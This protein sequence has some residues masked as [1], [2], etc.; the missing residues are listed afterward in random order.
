[1]IENLLGNATLEKILLS[2]QRYGDIY[3]NDIANTFDISLYCVQKQFQKMERSGVM[4]SR[5]YGKVRLYQF[6]PNYPLLNELR[7]LLNKT[8]D[9]LPKRDI[10][11]YYMKRQRPRLVGKK[12]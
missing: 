9:F 5:L 11:K 8:F 2:A 6:N 12:L 4:V 1:M 7:L 3:A 10:E